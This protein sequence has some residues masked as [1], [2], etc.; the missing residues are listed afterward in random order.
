M[1][2]DSILSEWDE[3]ELSVTHSSGMN[4]STGSSDTVIHSKTVNQQDHS[5]WLKVSISIQGQDVC[6][7]IRNVPSFTV[8]VSILQVI[9]FPIQ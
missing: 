7:F 2:R 6:V 3:Y 4:S 9:A 5:F 1:Q 8:I